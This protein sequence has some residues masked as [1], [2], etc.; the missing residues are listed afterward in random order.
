MTSGTDLPEKPLRILLIEDNPDDAGLV[1]AMLTEGPGAR[2]T[3][4]L[5]SGGTGDRLK[6]DGRGSI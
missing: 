4:E 3:V 6:T 5:P 1:R 2:F